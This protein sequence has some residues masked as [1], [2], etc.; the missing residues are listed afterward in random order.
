MGSNKYCLH[1]FSNGK[2]IRFLRSNDVPPVG[3]EIRLSREDFYKVVRAVWCFDE[4]D[5]NGQR[6][7]IE[8]KKVRV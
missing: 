6:V 8:V 1:V 5:E 2:R 3:D 4:K 7:N